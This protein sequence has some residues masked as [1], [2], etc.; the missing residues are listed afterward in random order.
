MMEH[1]AA[2]LQWKRGCLLTTRNECVVIIYSLQYGNTRKE[3]NVDKAAKQNMCLKTLKRNN[4]IIKYYN[5]GFISI[6]I[7]L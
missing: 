4:L 7:L 6:H 5:N 1:Y 2:V 3:K